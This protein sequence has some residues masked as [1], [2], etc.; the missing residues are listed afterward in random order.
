MG[1][2]GL[3]EGAIPFTPPIQ[4]RVIPSIIS[5]SRMSQLP[6]L[7]VGKVGDQK[8]TAVRSWSYS[9]SITGW[10]TCWRS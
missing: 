9:Q 2:T 4:F 5:G 10:H 6:W 8:P 1:L 3:T 7:L